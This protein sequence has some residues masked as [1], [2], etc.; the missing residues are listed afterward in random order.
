MSK[1][2][3]DSTKKT[4][5]SASDKTAVLLEARAFNETPLNPAKCRAIISKLILLIYQSTVLN[6]TEA[7]DIFFK[8]TKLFMNSSVPLRQMVYL[9]IKELAPVAND[10]LM[11]TSSLTK[12]MNGKADVVYRSNAIRALCR[13]TDV[14]MQMCSI[15]Y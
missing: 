13:I 11:V 1:R 12:D 7:T 6:P 14:R 15:I 2:D 4:T 5:F 3:E 10:I 8:I 9:A